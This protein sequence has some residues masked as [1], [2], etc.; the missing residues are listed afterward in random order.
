MPGICSPHRVGDCHS[1]RPPGRRPSREVDLICPSIERGAVRR[2]SHVRS[3]YHT[4]DRITIERTAVR[5]ESTDAVRRQRSGRAESAGP[6]MWR[7]SRPG[8]PAPDR[9]SSKAS[10]RG[11]R[12][13]CGGRRE[14]DQTP[15][16]SVALLDSLRELDG[17]PRHRRRPSGA[18]LAIGP[19]TRSDWPPYHRASDTRH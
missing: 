12:L 16:K 18:G 5:N 11:R 17:Q 3:R 8:E 4:P 13:G 15:G 6:S 19:A 2:V 14:T 1:R 9:L 10:E 7:L